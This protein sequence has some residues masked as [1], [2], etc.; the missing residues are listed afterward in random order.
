LKVTSSGLIDS[1]CFQPRTDPASEQEVFPVAP[2][3][4]DWTS[5][6][7]ESVTGDIPGLEAIEHPVR[8][9][10]EPLGDFTR[11]EEL[12]VHDD[13][14]GAAEEHIGA[15]L[16]P[17]VASVADLARLSAAFAHELGEQPGRKAERLQKLE[18]LRSRELRR[19]MEVEV[20]IERRLGISR[21]FGRDR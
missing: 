14:R 2:E 6:S 11:S 5:L 8:R 18:V 7:A 21:D 1:R 10:A 9:E 16:R 20:G 17:R 15:G 3:K 12:L 4:P 19:I 13:G